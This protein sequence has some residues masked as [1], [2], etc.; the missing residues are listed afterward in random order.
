[1]I[2]AP[3]AWEVTP[4]SSQTKIAVL[5][6]GIESNHP[7]LRDFVDTE[8]GESFVGGDTEDRAGHGTHVAGTIA[9]YV[10]VSGV[11]ITY[12]LN[13]IKDLLDDVTQL[14]LV[15]Y[16]IITLFTCLYTIYNH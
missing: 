10:Q 12:N 14:L 7:S 1:M 9:S 6:T 16:Y 8:L 2:K 4:G 15:I 13:S 11:M 5:D 3:E